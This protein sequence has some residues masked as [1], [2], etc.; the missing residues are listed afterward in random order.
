MF[1]LLFMTDTSWP[2]MLKYFLAAVL[3]RQRVLVAVEGQR[4]EGQVARLPSVAA[5]AAV[6]EEIEIA[7]AGD[8]GHPA[9]LRD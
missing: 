1:P 5:V 7:V 8:T 2:D 4:G 6:V 3:G 9:G